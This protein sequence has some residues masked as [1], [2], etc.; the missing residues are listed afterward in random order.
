MD[1]T[2]KPC[3]DPIGPRD[4]SENPTNSAQPLPLPG[5]QKASTRT[6]VCQFRNTVSPK[7][8]SRGWWMEGPWPALIPG[9]LRGS[10]GWGIR[11]LQRDVSLQTALIPWRILDCPR[12]WAEVQSGCRPGGQ[13][14]F[15]IPGGSTLGPFSAEL[16][17][18]FCSHNTS[19]KAAGN[20]TEQPW[21]PSLATGFPLP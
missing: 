13:E 18:Q 4:F 5:A 6:A 11:S 7:L 17:V 12:G 3:L 2:A 19:N 15:F 1:L 16:W 14:P 10:P 20:T 9:Q 8:S 21:A